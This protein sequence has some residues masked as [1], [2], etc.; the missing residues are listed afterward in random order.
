MGKETKTVRERLNWAYANLA[1]AEIA[2]HDKAALGS[3]QFI[4]LLIEIRG[5]L[6]Y[7]I[8]QNLLAMVRLPNFIS[9]GLS[10]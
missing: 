3:V 6:S 7:V 10:I 2:V 4:M 5:F 1:M 8:C 9:E